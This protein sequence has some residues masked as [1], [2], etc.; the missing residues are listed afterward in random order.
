MSTIY[1]RFKLTALSAAMLTAYGTAYAQEDNPEADA[2]IEEVIVTGI[3]ASIEKSIDD[4]RFSKN[5]VD[6][7]NAEDIGKTADQNIAEALSRV[8]GVS[9]QS[10]D[11]EGTTITVRGANANQNNI[12]LNGATLTST[13]FSQAVDLSAYSADILSKVEVVKTPSADHDE[14]SLGANVNLVTAKP[15]ELKDNVRSLTVQGRYNDFVDDTNH[16]ISGSFSHTFLDDTLGVIVTAYDET[17]SIRRDQFRVDDYVASN[18]A[19]I[20]RDQNG[21]VITNV[22]AIV[23]SAMG[24]ELHQ[25]ESNRRGLTAGVQWQ[26]TDTTDVMLNVTH[27][28]QSLVNSFTG[29]KTRRPN[30][31]NFFEGEEVIPGFPA[32]GFTDPQQDW[33]TIDTDTRTFTK[34]V[35]RAGPGDLTTS[36]GGSD[37]TNSVVSLELN[38]DITD[39]LRVS[40]KGGYSKS[41]Q[42]TIP[43]NAWLNMQNYMHVPGQVVMAIGPYG[44]EGGIEPVGY[45]C[46]SGECT[47]VFGSGFVDLGENI[48]AYEEVDD[49]GILQQ[50]PG[51]WDNTATTTFNPQDLRAQGISFL[52]RTDRKVEDKNQSFQVDFDWDV[53]KFGLTTAEFG[54]KYASRS[55]FVDDQSY[56]FSSSEV[57]D[58]IRNDEGHAI[59]VPG[60]SLLDISGEMIT[61]GESFPYDDFMS[62]LGYGRDNA[63]IGWTPVSGV[64]AL[65]LT[66]GAADIVGTRDDTDTRSADLDTIAAYIKTSFA[67][68]DDRLTGDIGLRYVETEVVATGYSG[69]TFASDR[70]NNL[71]RVFDHVKLAELRDTSLPACPEPGMYFEDENAPLAIERH[72]ERIDGLGYDVNSGSPDTW[73]PIPDAGACHEPL[74]AA[75][76]EFITS[77][78]TGE[79]PFVNWETMQR[80]ADIS[81]SHIYAWGANWGKEFDE[82]GALVNTNQEDRSIVAIP[83]TNSH[84]YSTIL[85]SLNL[86]YII[87]DDLIGRFALSKTMARPPIDQLR[88]G[89]SGTE[90]PWPGRTNNQVDMY[91]TKLDPLESKNIDF[92][93]EWYFD[94]SAMVAGTVFHKDMTN[95]ATVESLRTYLD[96]LRNLDTSVPYDSS[97]LAVIATDNAADDYGL[98]S[99]FPKRS[100]ADFPF[101]TRD[102]NWSDDLRDLCAQFNVNKT[103]NGSGATVTG[104]ELQYTQSYDFLPSYWAG[105]GTSVNYTY[106]QSEYDKEQSSIDSNI[107]LPSYPV[108][109]TPEHTYNA[110]VFWE[111][112]D[113]QLRLAYRGNSD[114]LVGTDSNNGRSGRTWNQGSLWN[115]GRA[116]LDFSASWQVTDAVDLTFQAI[117]LTDAE[118]RTYFTSRTLAIDPIRDE[119]GTITGWEEYDEGTPM[120]NDA[121]TSRTVA[122]YKNGRTFRLGVR[123]NF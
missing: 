73:T 90:D 32:A 59:A 53:D 43:D 39:T 83:T 118:N 66:Q 45:D 92:S 1:N 97:Q 123:V 10:R 121:T 29:L 98:A 9:L 4:K 117:N 54:A 91:N 6:T 68:M 40:V 105:L 106:Q 61:T 94:E 20:A 7:I 71:E 24:Y 51:W 13:D 110:T 50:R 18:T 36:E 116:T 108:A 22:R 78:A 96:D 42:V 87:K 49:D 72:L 5:I 74:L 44:S 8:T 33:W 11:G 55:K 26:P 119:N 93:L 30:T 95:F 107:T 84:K 31:P 89:F 76:A 64:K 77:G 86:N 111:H 67:F 114:S 14:G 81:Q 21:E 65:E 47:M 25:N 23:P 52:S 112:E 35:N 113:V 16:K 46:T 37:N 102:E 79:A 28:E 38:Q 58:I 82:N 57:A 120:D 17:S 69:F 56:Q 85:P 60:G 15:L 104:I 109:D 75:R 70:G 27:S 122:R 41:E 62:S 34:Y 3:R 115:E 99:C 103:V 101:D 2:N 12:T 48:T 19:R 100:I 80:H 88:P 63:T